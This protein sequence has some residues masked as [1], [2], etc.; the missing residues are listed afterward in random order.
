[1]RNAWAAASPEATARS[2]SVLYQACE[3]TSGR[4]SETT[5]CSGSRHKEHTHLA[6]SGRVPERRLSRSAIIESLFRTSPRSSRKTAAGGPENKEARID[7]TR[8]A[9]H[10]RI[11]EDVTAHR[12]ILRYPTDGRKVLVNPPQLAWAVADQ[13]RA[14]SPQPAHVPCA[15]GC[16][17]ARR[18]L[19]L[20]RKI[21]SELI[22]A[23]KCVRIRHVN[24][25]KRHLLRSE[26]P[27]QNDKLREL[28]VVG[29][30]HSHPH[31]NRAT[32]SA[33]PRGS[34]RTPCRTHQDRESPRRWRGSCHRATR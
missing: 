32:R 27:R 21:R 10:G 33:P 20:Q 11:L 12:R 8:C 29:A 16:P 15:R 3:C 22:D 2:G 26:R 24:G 30:L 31:R 5:R 6:H 34:L 9:D 17:R 19:R 13:P 23:T 7:T 25:E 4:K 28:P 14:E 18:V 1:M